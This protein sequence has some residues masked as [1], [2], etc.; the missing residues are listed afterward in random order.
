[1]FGL[2]QQPQPKAAFSPDPLGIGEAIFEPLVR[3]WAGWLIVAHIIIQ[4]ML[5]NSK[6]AL[7]SKP[8]VAAHQLVV[9]IP[10]FYAAMV[11]VSN[12]FSAERLDIASDYTYERRL[13]SQFPISWDL[14]R[15]MIGFQFYELAACVLEHS[16]FKTE[17]ILHHTMALTT[18]LVASGGPY[19]QYSASF[20]FGI[21]EISSCPLAIVDLYREFPKIHEN[22]KLHA[23]INELARVLF[24]ISF[25]VVRCICWPSQVSLMASDFISAYNA[26]D[27]RSP[28][29]YI[30]AFT[31][32]V[33][34]ALQY[35]WG[36]KIC[37]ALVKMLKGD[38]SDRDKEA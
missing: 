20:F 16:L 38:K 8:G 22:S 21:I 2:G 34:T 6:T 35:F 29:M 37:K 5:S 10:F 24:A 26:G 32:F 1:M 14:N 28:T 25:L 4:F 15:F 12:F 11:G 13:Y 30:F 19:L 7:S 3:S 17:H 27:I 18:S 31:C 36:F 33:L 9:M 23:T